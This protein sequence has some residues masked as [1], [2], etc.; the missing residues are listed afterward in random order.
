MFDAPVDAWYAWLGLA[1]AAT[2]SL[3]AVSALPTAPPP[4]ARAVAGTV[5]AVAAADAPAAARYRLGADAVRVT[6]GGVSL[7]SD[8]GTAV[9]RFRAPTGTIVPVRPGGPLAG[10][11]L[12]DPLERSYPTRAG[13]AD[14]VAAARRG[15]ADWVAGRTL[16][17]RHVSWGETDVTLVLVA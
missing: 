10:V 8:G 7:R 13:F 4:D 2:V 9:A 3:G 15:E 14:A 11:A 5:D 1:A 12:G 17:A 6:A 16:H